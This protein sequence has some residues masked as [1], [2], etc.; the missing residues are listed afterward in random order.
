M[1]RQSAG[2]RCA[3]CNR[4]KT[5]AELTPTRFIPDSPFGPEVSEFTCRGCLEKK[6]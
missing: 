5:W 3:E 2:N 1:A 4:F 6:E